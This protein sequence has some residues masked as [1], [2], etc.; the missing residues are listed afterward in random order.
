MDSF[1]G[2]IMTRGYYS[3][4]TSKRSSLDKTHCILS[5]PLL[6]HKTRTAFPE[7]KNV[8]QNKEMHL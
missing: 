7:G 8:L 2:I 6:Q 5:S 4:N 3:R 1:A